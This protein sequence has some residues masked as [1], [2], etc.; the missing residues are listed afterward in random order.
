MKRRECSLC[1]VDFQA[2]AGEGRCPVC[3][4]H[5]ARRG[6]GIGRTT[7]RTT[8]RNCLKCGRPFP[9]VGPANRLCRACNYENDLFRLRVP[10]VRRHGP[11]LPP[12]TADRAL[13]RGLRECD[14][15]ED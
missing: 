13:I 7:D 6:R 2:R 3:R 11:K 9:S 12:Q 10:R 14:L 1:G 15:L 8:Q 4:N 5:M